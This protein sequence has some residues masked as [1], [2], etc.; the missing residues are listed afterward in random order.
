MPE[1]TEYKIEWTCETGYEVVH[2][3]FRF[4]MK[5]G[6]LHQDMIAVNLAYDYLKRFV[7]DRR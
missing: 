5:G 3:P 1:E 4:P 6:G 2:G 7:H